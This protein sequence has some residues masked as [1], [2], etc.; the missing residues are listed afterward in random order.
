VASIDSIIER[1]ESLS[2][3]RREFALASIARSPHLQWRRVSDPVLEVANMANGAARASLLCGRMA[4]AQDA[5]RRA[6]RTARD[7][8]ALARKR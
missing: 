6:V 3:A 2:S 4:G 7:L 8:R 5:A 1:L